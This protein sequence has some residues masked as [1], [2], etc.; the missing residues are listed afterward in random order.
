MRTCMLPSPARHRPGKE[1]EEW[2]KF[3]AAISAL[4]ERAYQ[5]LAQVVRLALLVDMLQGCSKGAL[6]VL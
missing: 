3:D 4:L 5:E 6:R 1:G 2:V